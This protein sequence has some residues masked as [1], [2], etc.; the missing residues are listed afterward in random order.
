MALTTPQELLDAYDRYGAGC[1]ATAD[2]WATRYSRDVRALLARIAEL[3]Q[4]REPIHTK[5]RHDLDRST[6]FTVLLEL[7][8]GWGDTVDDGGA[9]VT[10]FLQDW[11]VD[12]SLDMAEFAR[13]WI[14]RQT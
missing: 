12:P 10:R 2:T 9:D 11:Y 5:R 3:E 6:A 8:P 1:L 14:A 4:D 13:R 7:Y